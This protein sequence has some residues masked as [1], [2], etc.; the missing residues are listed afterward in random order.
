VQRSVSLVTVSLVLG[1]LTLAVCTGEPVHVPEAA[2]RV[3]SVAVPR[4]PELRSVFVYPP[5]GNTVDD[6]AAASDLVVLGTFDEPMGPPS[7]VDLLTGDGAGLVGLPLQRWTFDVEET[8][9]TDADTDADTGAGTDG[10]SGASGPLV[11]TQLVPGDGLV[12]GGSSLTETG[13]R[14]VLFLQR[15]GDDGYMVT[16]LGDGA[17][18]M[19]VQRDPESAPAAV[20]TTVSVVAG[21]DDLRVRLGEG[22]PG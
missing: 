4:V 9:R 1:G 5:A 17:L 3:A 16:G 14:A 21:L 13:T 12:E 11:V 7:V 20:D 15:Y 10:G 2:A 8:F 18:V 19:T 22:S 6:L